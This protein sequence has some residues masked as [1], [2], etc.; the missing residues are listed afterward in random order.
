MAGG[1]DVLAYTLASR[2]RDI[3][4]L[5]D[6]LDR[7]EAGTGDWLETQSE[8]DRDA[9]SLEMVL[10]AFRS[11]ADPANF[12]ILRHLVEQTSIPMSRLQGM[13]SMDRFSLNERL[14]D[15]IQVGLA[16]R[17]IDT[18]HAQITDAGSAMA[19]LLLDVQHQTSKRLAEVLAPKTTLE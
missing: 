14:S 12:N 1:Q 5:L 2:L 17:E 4:R 8:A 13:V 7:L 9:A 19:R 18:D 3:A 10:R 15:L 16:V 6:R 11:A